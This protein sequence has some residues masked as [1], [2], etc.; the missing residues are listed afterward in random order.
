MNNQSGLKNNKKST[1]LRLREKNIKSIKQKIH[2][3][4][5][6]IQFR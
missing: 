2:T 4:Y 3:F 5:A 6:P 1:T